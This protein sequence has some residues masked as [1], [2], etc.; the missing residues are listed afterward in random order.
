[1]AAAPQQPQHECEF[2]ATD[3]PTAK[4]RCETC[5]AVCATIPVGSFL[6]ICVSIFFLKKLYFK[7]F[8]FNFCRFN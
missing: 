3:D 2:E 4:Y 1:M 8:L 6:D 5:N 7:V